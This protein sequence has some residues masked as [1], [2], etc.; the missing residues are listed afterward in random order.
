MLASA[1]G[2]EAWDALAAIGE[3]ACDVHL[4]CADG[5]VPFGTVCTMDGC[6]GSIADMCRR[7]PAARVL[8]FEGAGHSIHNTRRTEFV[9][10][11]REVVDEAARR[12]PPVIRQ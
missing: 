10:A 1:D 5:A 8:F 12:M 4:W 2:A 6:D 3:R 7:L 11:L 9:G